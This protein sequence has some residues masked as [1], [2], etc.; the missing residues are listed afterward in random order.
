MHNIFSV[1]AIE[2]RAFFFLAGFCLT[3]SLSMAASNVFLALT[4]LSFL[5]RLVRK[6]DDVVEFY[7][8]NSTILKFLFA[9]I[10]SVILSS[11]FSGSA[12]YSLKSA[13]DFYIYR[14]MPFFITWFIVKNKRQLLILLL[15]IL[16]SVTL[17]S[18]AS[19]GQVYLA[20]HYHIDSI[21]RFSGLIPYMAQATILS[22]AVPLL[23]IAAAHYKKY[24]E[25]LLFALLISLLALFFNMTRG[26]WFATLIT[27]I[28]LIIIYNK[29]FKI[30]ALMVLLFSL[31]GFLLYKNVPLFEAR[32]NTIAKYNIEDSERMKLITSAYNMWRDNPVFG[33]G[34]SRFKID[35]KEKYI[36]PDAKEREL[37]HAHNNVMHVLAETG[38]VGEA[39][40]LA[41]WCYLA[42]FAFKNWRNSRNPYALFL[43]AVILAV[44]LH[45]LS[46]YT[47][48]A[49]RTIKIVFL[50]LG[51]G[52]RGIDIEK[53]QA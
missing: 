37:E 9:L 35:Y 19:I 32:V 28:I 7:E 12:E 40:F 44:H 10:A 23:A 39:A 43:L 22:F 4:V 3:I 34:F 20:N 46:E 45:G 29:N 33:I 49:S 1:E 6:H 13:V 42:Y 14:I 17:N 11:L 25:M 21:T 47:L 26:A 16:L 48:G 51:I 24:R 18:F 31:V 52:L 36:L 8:K 50:A 5:H 41:F 2:K 53:E 38:M 30:A 27:F 15:L